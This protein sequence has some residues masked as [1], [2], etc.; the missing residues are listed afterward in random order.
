MKRDEAERGKR[1]ETRRGMANKRS[2]RLAQG[3]VKFGD[4]QAERTKN[5]PYLA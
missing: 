1:G 5:A 3:A 4:I 2:A